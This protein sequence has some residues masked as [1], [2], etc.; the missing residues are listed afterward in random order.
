MDNMKYN[1]LV[2]QDEEGKYI[3]E[4]VDLPGCISDGKSKEDV[5]VNIKEAIKAYNESYQKEK[6]ESKKGQLVEVVV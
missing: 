6:L 4:C 2:Y 3:A 1:V 5:L